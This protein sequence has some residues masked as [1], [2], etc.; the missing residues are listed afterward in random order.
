[1][2]PGRNLRTRAWVL[3]GLAMCLAVLGGPRLAEGLTTSG[4]SDRSVAASSDHGTVALSPTTRTLAA[5]TAG[6]ERSTG[7]LVDAVLTTATALPWRPVGAS[8]TEHRATSAVRLGGGQS[9][10]PPVSS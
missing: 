3:A 7:H 10:A 9:R 4:V 1:M 5:G 2:T 6:S 8:S